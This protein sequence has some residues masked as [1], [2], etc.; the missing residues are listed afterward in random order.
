ME[1][2]LHIE[3]LEIPY[4]FIKNGSIQVFNAPSKVYNLNI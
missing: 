1:S 3:Q 4:K 2:N